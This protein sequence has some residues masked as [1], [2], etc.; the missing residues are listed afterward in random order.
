[1]PPFLGFS[2]KS[3]H[4]SPHPV[5]PSDPLLLST[6]YGVHS[7]LW[8]R[9]DVST[10]SLCLK[11]A[12]ILSGKIKVLW[13]VLAS[14]QVDDE[15]NVFLSRSASGEHM[16]QH[17]HPYCV[18]CTRKCVSVHRVNGFSRTAVSSPRMIQPAEGISLNI[19]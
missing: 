5:S 17:L 7:P 4:T 19:L 16:S 10:T 15:D 9:V 6:P 2:L 1:M 11:R 12:N 8:Q 14:Y 18:L 13:E 3:L